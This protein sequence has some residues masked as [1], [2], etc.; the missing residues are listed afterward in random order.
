MEHLNTTELK[1]KLFEIVSK[2]EGDHYKMEADGEESFISNAFKFI[3]RGYNYMVYDVNNDTGNWTQIITREDLEGVL[4]FIQVKKP[5]LFSVF[6]CHYYLISRN[7]CI[8]L[9]KNDL[10]IETDGKQWRFFSLLDL[11][12]TSYEEFHKHLE[13]AHAEKLKYLEDKYKQEVN[14]AKKLKN[15]IDEIFT[16]S[17]KDE[18]N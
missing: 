12:K 4:K 6:G 11:K 2:K 10:R 18:N 7:K 15:Q 16:K 3:R 17:K 5:Y 9:D 1:Q 14:I 13:K 8:V